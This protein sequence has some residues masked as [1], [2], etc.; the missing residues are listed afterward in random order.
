MTGEVNWSK[1][2]SGLFSDSDQSSLTIKLDDIPDV[3]ETGITVA[4]DGNTLQVT[5]TEVLSTDDVDLQPLY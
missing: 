2:I 3:D 1:D 5:A 4:L